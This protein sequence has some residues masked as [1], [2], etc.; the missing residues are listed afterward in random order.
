L[1]KAQASGGAFKLRESDDHRPSRAMPSSLSPAPTRLLSEDDY[2]AMLATV[3][4]KRGDICCFLLF[5][6]PDPQDLRV[7]V[8]LA[9]PP[10]FQPRDAIERDETRGADKLMKIG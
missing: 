8:L 4:A 7:G 10:R 2:R 3:G 5:H 9:K 1:Q 6:S